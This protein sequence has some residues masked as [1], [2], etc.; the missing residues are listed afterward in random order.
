MSYLIGKFCEQTHLPV[1]GRTRTATFTFAI[2]PQIVLEEV[3]PFLPPPL[4]P[5]LNSAVNWTLRWRQTLSHAS[6]RPLLSS[7]ESAR[8]VR[9]VAVAAP[10]LPSSSPPAGRALLQPPARGAPKSRYEESNFLLEQHGPEGGDAAGYSHFF[11]M[12]VIIQIHS[13]VSSFTWKKKHILQ[14]HRLLDTN[15]FITIIII[16]LGVQ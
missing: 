6:G 15:I 13:A 8:R 1:G 10:P 5:S 14:L 2:V 3:S 12:P 4:P 9:A 11:C 16:I 7:F